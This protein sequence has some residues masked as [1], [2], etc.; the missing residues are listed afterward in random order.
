MNVSTEDPD[1]AR[2]ALAG[3]L[4]TQRQAKKKGTLSAERISRLTALGVI[5]DQCAAAFDAHCAALQQIKDAGGEVNVSTID[6][7]PARK[8]LG[9]WL[10]TQRGAKRNDRLSAERISRLEALGVSWDMDAAALDAHCAALQEIKDA[11]GDVNVSQGDPVPARKRLGQWLG[12]QRQA[13]KKGTLSAERISRLEALGVWW[14]K[15]HVGTVTW[16]ERYGQLCAIRDA[17]GDV[18]ISQYDPDPARKVLG[19]WLATQ[20][21]RKKNDRLSAERISRLE[22]LGVWWSKSR[23]P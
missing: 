7:D 19:K 16:D 23:T 13:K 11:G 2:K 12:T 8:V 17:G 20:R 22:A 21:N 4:G 6:P 5:W 9:N 3:W 18:N 10:R 15:S 1:P 14:G